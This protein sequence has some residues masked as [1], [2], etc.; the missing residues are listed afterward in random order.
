MTSSFS[1]QV[2]ADMSQQFRAAQL[3]LN[4][5]IIEPKYW[6]WSA[7]CSTSEFYAIGAVTQHDW[8]TAMDDDEPRRPIKA[9]LAHAV[10]WGAPVWTLDQDHP[11]ARGVRRPRRT[12]GVFRRVRAWLCRRV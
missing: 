6:D 7:T 5:A 4:T 10:A 3:G 8:T 2:P 9:S 11:P 1:E 12:P